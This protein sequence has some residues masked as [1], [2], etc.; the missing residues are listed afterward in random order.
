M[1]G[2][3]YRNIFKKNMDPKTRLKQPRQILAWRVI[4]KNYEQGAPNPLD[5]WMLAARA[6]NKSS[7]CAT[8]IEQNMGFLKLPSGYVK[9]AIEAMAQSK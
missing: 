2:K 4:G 5:S 8:S 7:P 6:S 9:V 3:I 1:G